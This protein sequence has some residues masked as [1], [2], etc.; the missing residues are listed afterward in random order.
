M[1]LP[2]IAQTA[3]VSATIIPTIIT[4][5]NISPTTTPQPTPLP[6]IITNI[7]SQVTKGQEFSLNLNLHT[8][9]NQSYQLKIYGGVNGDNYSI[10]VKN[11][12]N[13]INGYNGAWDSLPQVITDNDG[14]S[15]FP[16]K[17]RFK[18]DKTSGTS[19]LIAKIKETTKNSYIL[20]SAYNLEV[21]DPPPPTSTPTDIPPTPTNT[22]MPTSIPPTIP[23]TPTITS[24]STII[25][26]PTITIVPTTE[27]I[28]S[29]VIPSTTIYP[30]I[31]LALP[32]STSTTKTDFLP[33]ILVGAGSLLLLVP[34]LIAKLGK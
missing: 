9:A 10:E 27:L 21:I 22:P 16:L 4:P 17:L 11:G 13:W 30:K 28:T 6:L 33:H 20:S 29:Q 23:P 14:N 31:T 1:I 24:I 26:K 18:I 34:L 2:V 19:Q 25:S 7:P 5:T 15:N 8:K 32:A 3:T 12:T